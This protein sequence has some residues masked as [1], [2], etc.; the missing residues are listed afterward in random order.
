MSFFWGVFWA[1]FLQFHSMGQFLAQKRT[2]LTVVIGVGVDTLLLLPVIPK[3]AWVKLLAVLGLSSIP[4]ILRS[5]INELTETN[6]AI[7][8]IKRHAD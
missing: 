6:E 7:D 1:S 3:R 5:L 4:I 2:W 8:V